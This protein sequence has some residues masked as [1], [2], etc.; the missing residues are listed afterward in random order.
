MPYAPK[1]GDTLLIP[2]GP[3][4][5]PDRMHLHCV[6][7]GACGEEM[8][9]VVCIESIV[10]G[11]FHDP[12]CELADGEH[13]F[14]TK[15]SYVNF[16]RTQCFKVARLTKMVDG[17]LYKPKPPLSEALLERICEGVLASKMTPRGMKDYFAK[18]VPPK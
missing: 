10:E 9:L 7:T 3:S 11:A 5:D 8:H 13:E 18:Q 12:T 2:S 16:R 14:V 17:W 15:P 6:L 4:H 1:R